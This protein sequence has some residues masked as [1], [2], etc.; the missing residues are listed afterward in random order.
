MKKYFLDDF[1]TPDQYRQFIELMVTKSEYFSLV[2][3]SKTEGERKKAGV[4]AIYDKLKSAKVAAWRRNS[5]PRTWTR[6][7]SGHVYR[8][9]LYH[10]VPQVIPCLSQPGSL[11]EWQ[12]PD[13]PMDLCFYRDGYCWFAVTAHEGEAVLYTDDTHI[14]E[15]IRNLGTGVYCHGEVSEADL[16]LLRAL[17]E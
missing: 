1:L 8:L 13:A 6:N 5:W 17:Y 7:D 3:F 16:F 14:V 2:Y 10:S 11:F 9:V 4:K 15:Y 12:Y